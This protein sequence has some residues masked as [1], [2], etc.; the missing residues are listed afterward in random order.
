MKFKGWYIEKQNTQWY[1]YV[2]F[3]CNMGWN[4]SLDIE[5]IQLALTKNFG[6]PIKWDV[7][8]TKQLQ[9]G[10]RKLSV[11]IRVYVMSCLAHCGT[12]KWSSL[13]CL[14]RSN[15][16]MPVNKKYFIIFIHVVNC[17]IIYLPA[18]PPPKKVPLWDCYVC[19]SFCN[20]LLCSVLSSMFICFTLVLKA[21]SQNFILNH[22]IY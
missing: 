3:Q 9:T 20:A 19:P 1:I 18:S 14:W 11:N 17:Y 4:P 16:I 22:S 6:Q 21:Q 10:R 13:F 8:V 7:T 2:E 5:M 12:S 15:F